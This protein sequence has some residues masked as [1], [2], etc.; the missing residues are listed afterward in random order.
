M[1]TENIWNQLAKGAKQNKKLVIKAILIIVVVEL[2]ILAAGIGIW[3]IAHSLLRFAVYLIAYIRPIRQWFYTH[4]IPNQEFAN[5]AMPVMNLN[6][7]I[8]L[9]FSLTMNIILIALGGW[10]IYQAG[11]LGQNLI[12]IFMANSK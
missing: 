6:G 12:Y 4:I 2:V 5:Q 1:Q 3:I 8:R 9:I 10:I 7:R 11:F